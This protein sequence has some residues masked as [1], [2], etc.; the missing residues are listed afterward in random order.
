MNNNYY[1]L[2]R[3]LADEGMHVDLYLINE[4]EQFHPINDT[5]KLDNRINLIDYDL[6]KY[7]NDGEILNKPHQDHIRKTFEDY[8]AKFGCGY[9][10]A[11]MSIGGL[12]LDIFDPYGADLRSLPKYVPSKKGVVIIKI[13]NILKIANLIKKFN[14]II[15]LSI[16]D[17]L[18][19]VYIM[20]HLARHQTKGIKNS[21]FIKTTDE[22]SEQYFKA[23]DLEPEKNIQFAS[24][25]VYDYLY[26]PNNI[27]KYYNNCKYYN[28][29]KEIR[30]NNR[31]VIFH[32]NRIQWHN[33][34]KAASKGTIDFLNGF[35]D[36]VVLAN[37]DDICLVLFEYGKD[38]ELTKQ[39]IAKKGLYKYVRWMPLMPRKAIM[40]GLSLADI[41]C[42][43]FVSGNALCGT[44]AEILCSGKILIG[45]R[46]DDYF[47]KNFK[48]L[49]PMVN[50][51]TVQ[52]ITGALIDINQHFDKYKDVA[53]GGRKWFLKYCVKESL[54][55]Y[56]NIIKEVMKEKQ[57]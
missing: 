2:A 17:K 25:Y 50:V 47:S 23:L 56:K 34:S 42:G 15:R 6:K 31:L 32:H 44:I 49:Y 9:A 43:Q 35:N 30:D 39:F 14:G 16:L 54:N 11:I 4:P 53:I 24:S 18:L 21:K 1:T 45:Y 20:Y 46:D 26:S 41:G 8:D 33:V 5:F 48:E 52:E 37:S 57:D 13:L 36:F 27:I 22:S 51:R 55:G 10:P 19:S 28:I 3:Y 40:I 7:I 29:F 38:V 12:V